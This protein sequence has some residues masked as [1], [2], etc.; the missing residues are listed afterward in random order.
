MKNQF[1][2]VPGLHK[3]PCHVA[4]Q[5][6]EDFADL[7]VGINT[8][9]KPS[10]CL[11]DAIIAMEGDG[12]AN[13]T[14]RHMGL[15]LASR[16]PVAMDWAEGVL[17]GYDPTTLPVVTQALKHGL[18]QKPSY[19]LL[20]AGDLAFKDWQR[21]PQR[22]SNLVR[23]LLLPFFTRR[24]KHEQKRPA[25]VFGSPDCILCQRCVQ[26]CP[27]NAL[28][29]RGKTIEIDQRRCVR[30]YCCHEMCPANAITIKERV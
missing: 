15:L 1:G 10:W 7:I 9:F 29:V 28:T 26:I 19:P 22:K 14:P 2:L 3:S 13:G 23:D 17:M 27:A 12:P 4:K 25:P 11:M 24:F 18:G 8:L 5:S 21:I 20:N 16:D 30:C 6:R